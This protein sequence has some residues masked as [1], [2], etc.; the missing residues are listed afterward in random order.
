[1]AEVP[2]QVWL[3]DLAGSRSFGFRSNDLWLQCAAAKAGMG[4]AALPVF[5]GRAQGLERTHAELGMSRDIWLTYHEDLRSSPQ[6]ARV[7]RFLA[8]QM[9]QAEQA[10]GAWQSRRDPGMG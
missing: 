7:T 8:E 4:I 9:G 6:L 2:Q 3:D 1:M 5:L 10:G